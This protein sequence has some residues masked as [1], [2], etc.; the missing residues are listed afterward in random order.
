MIPRAPSFKILF[1]GKGCQTVAGWAIPVMLI[2]VHLP[3]SS[4]DYVLVLVDLILVTFQ[5]TIY[6]LHFFFFLI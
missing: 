5:V 2:P 1:M 6:I 3:S 4:E